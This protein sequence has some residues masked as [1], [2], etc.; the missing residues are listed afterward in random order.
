MAKANVFYNAKE[1]RWEIRNRSGAPAAIF[2]DDGYN[3]DYGGRITDGV[4]SLASARIT[5]AAVG[6]GKAISFITKLSG[7][8]PA[9]AVGTGLGK[10][11]TVTNMGSGAIAVGDIIHVVQKGALAGQV[12]IGGAYVPTTN[13]VNVYVTNPHPGDIGSMPHVGIDVL[14]MRVA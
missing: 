1:R 2:S 14:Q 11:G 13:V 9:I 12:M 4:A 7:T 3:K 5:S 10:I 8:L 6:A